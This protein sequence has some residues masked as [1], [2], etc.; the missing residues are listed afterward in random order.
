MLYLFQV[1]TMWGES[2]TKNQLRSLF[3]SLGFENSLLM[4]FVMQQF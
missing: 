3:S 1:K 2:A 4:K